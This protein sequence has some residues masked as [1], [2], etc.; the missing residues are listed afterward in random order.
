MLGPNLHEKFSHRS[1][2]QSYSALAPRGILLLLQLKQ[3][4]F[5]AKLN[6]VTI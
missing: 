5:G 2:Q 1:H 6:R 4:D 3:H